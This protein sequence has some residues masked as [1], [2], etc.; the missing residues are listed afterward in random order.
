MRKENTDDAVRLTHEQKLSLPV[1]AREYSRY[2]C[3]DFYSLKKRTNNKIFCFCFFKLNFFI[4]TEF[5]LIKS[6]HKCEICLN[7]NTVFNFALAFTKFS[8]S[9]IGTLHVSRDDMW[10]NFLNFFLMEKICHWTVK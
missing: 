8:T 2:V 9:F 4:T 3:S 1:R 6:K 7:L 5:L 10:R